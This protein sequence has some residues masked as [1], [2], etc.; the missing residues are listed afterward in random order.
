M[1]ALDTNVVV[2]F[3]ANDDS[4]QSARA[5]GVLLAG[6]ILLTKTVLLE[7]AWVLRGAYGLTRADIGLALRKLL[8][9]AGVVAEDGPAVAKAL[10]WYERGVDFADALHL[11]SSGDADRF[12][13][14]DRALV[15]QCKSLAGAP[16]AVEPCWPWRW[17]GPKS[18]IAESSD[19]VVAAVSLP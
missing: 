8:G 15:R 6:D 11:A 5:E 1:I 17:Y 13:T 14:F 9:L 3:L 4:N 19:P 18:P 12:V 2:R 16:A 7:T 10:D